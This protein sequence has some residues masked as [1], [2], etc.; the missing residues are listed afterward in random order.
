[1]YY[2]CVTSF[3]FI[4]VIFVIRSNNLPSRC[5][6]RQKF[7]ID[8]FVLS[9]SSGMCQSAD[10]IFSGISA[11]ALHRPDDLMPEEKNRVKSSSLEF[12]F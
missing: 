5:I 7:I 1:M 2:I 11:L 4:L 10:R 9:T 12:N 3:D 8:V 6:Q